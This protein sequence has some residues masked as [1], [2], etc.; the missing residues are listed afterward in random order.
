M[1]QY[2]QDVDYEFL[3]WANDRLSV[4]LDDFVKNIQ[5]MEQASLQSVLEA[6][7]ALAR[8]QRK[9]T[10][11]TLGA[12][13]DIGKFTHRAVMRNEKG[14]ATEEGDLEKMA[15]ATWTRIEP[16][17]G[18]CEV[19]GC[20]LKNIGLTFHEMAEV[21]A[22]LNQN[23]P[24]KFT[25]SFHRLR[26]FLLTSPLSFN[27]VIDAPNIAY[28]RQNYEGGRFQYSQIALVVDALKKQGEE[29]LIILPH[30]Y[31]KKIVPNHIQNFVDRPSKGDTDRG[32]AVEVALNISDCGRPHVYSKNGRKNNLH[33][34]TLLQTTAKS[35]ER[36][37]LWKSQILTKNELAL[38]QSWRDEGRLFVTPKGAN[39][40]WYW[41]YASVMDEEL[42]KD[43]E[44]DFMFSDY[45]IIGDDYGKENRR[46]RAVDALNHYQWGSTRIKRVPRRLHVVTNDQMRDHWSS[47]VP[48][49]AFERWKQT[50]MLRFDIL[51]HPFK[52]TNNYSNDSSS[53]GMKKI[54]AEEPAKISEQFQNEQ[55][56]QLWM[57][58]LPS[59]LS[60]SG[61]SN[62]LA[63][64]FANSQREK[65]YSL[66]VKE[67]G[68]S[69]ICFLSSSKV[70]EEHT[71]VIVLVANI[72]LYSPIAQR[73]SV[74]SR[75]SKMN[76]DQ[77]IVLSNFSRKKDSPGIRRGAEF[78][79]ENSAQRGGIWH[80]P[81]AEQQWLCL[82]IGRGT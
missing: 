26:D 21:R 44:A 53:N 45:G 81:S 52:T 75:A 30:K 41:I 13:T 78:E 24:S 7:S 37:K 20:Q 56:D 18:I 54:D 71:D 43:E 2:P 74:I 10:P 67:R 35:A 31:T 6:C 16:T 28:C 22:A 25:N 55:F 59:M 14:A 70:I 49:V 23:L 50:T 58:G 69:N 42:S 65:Y 38:L 36:K 3:P 17:S 39:D 80:L 72:P 33:D 61:K 40:D 51:R 73:T 8:G 19:S 11:S 66:S 68:K 64:C 29:P 32:G 76:P 77:V 79:E 9:D 63:E 57:S 34:E 82:E 1:S 5:Y 12:F 15:R 47:L 60:L 48:P 46:R 27:I 4:L 62:Q